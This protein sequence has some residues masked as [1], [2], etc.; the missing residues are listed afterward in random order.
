MPINPDVVIIG[1]GIIGC[2]CA[3]YLSQAGVKVHLVDRGPLGS[4]ASKAG[5]MHVVTWEE[6]EIHLKLSARSKDLYQ[7]LSQQLPMD[8]N[9][10][11]TGSIAIVEKPDSMD[12]FTRTIQRLTTLGV[13]AALLSPADLVEMEPCIA[14]DVAGGVFFPD[15]AQ[16]NPLYATLALAQAAS[17]AGAILDLNNE[18]TGFELSTGEDRLNAVQTVHGR[19]SSNIA[20]LCAGAWSAG[21]GRMVGLDIPIKPRK[22]ILLV[23]APVSDALLHCKVILAAGYMDS[24][25]NGVSGEVAVAP[26]IQQAQNG[27]LVLGSCRQF[28]GF[29]TSVDPRVAARMLQRCLRFF[30][31]LA[32]VP[33]IRTWAGFRPYTPDLLPIIS[34]VEQISGMYIAAGHEGIGI[35]E[36]PVTGKLVS[37]MITGQQPE[38]SINELSFSRFQAKASLA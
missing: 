21:L 15:D 25:K 12:S 10:R 28:V 18:V 29:D 38:I 26:N 11:P 5:M 8:I 32:N 24:L 7:Q 35:T 22:G 2:S 31:F 30:P 34:P 17:S 27:N 36:A 1:A 6:P 13:R 33:V 19:I 9:Y 4:G 16:V 37:Q 3:Y 20:I 23:T 14:S